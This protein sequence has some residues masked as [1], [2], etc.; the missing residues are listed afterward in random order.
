MVHEKISD[1]ESGYD[2]VA[3]EYARRLY[4]ER[5]KNEIRADD[6]DVLEAENN[7]GR[8]WW[9]LVEAINEVRRLFHHCG[10]Y[11]GLAGDNNTCR[12]FV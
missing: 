9:P 7:P 11:R 12:A 4:D 8:K 3:D 2:L 5:Q 10:E 1:V 6:R